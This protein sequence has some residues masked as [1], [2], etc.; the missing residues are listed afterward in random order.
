[1]IA[2]LIRW[3]IVNRF[4]VLL[5]TLPSH[6]GALSAASIAASEFSGAARQSPRC[7]SR[8]V[9]IRRSSCADPDSGAEP[10]M[11]RGVQRGVVDRR[12]VEGEPA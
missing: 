1:M 2:R 10:E 5:A 8:S 4:L 12:A 3:S 11:V 7:A 9:V 6:S